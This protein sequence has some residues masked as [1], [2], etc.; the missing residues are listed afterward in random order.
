M[1]IK[2]ILG[3]LDPTIGTLAKS[4]KAKIDKMDGWCDNP[5]VEYCCKSLNSF[6]YLEKKHQAVNCPKCG[7]RANIK[8]SYKI[9]KK[10]CTAHVLEGTGVAC[11]TKVHAVSSFDCKLLGEESTFVIDTVGVMNSNPES[12]ASFASDNSS[13]M[14]NMEFPT[15]GLNVTVE[16]A[17]S[18]VIDIALHAAVYSPL[19][20]YVYAALPAFA[21]AGS[22]LPTFANAVSKSESDPSV[23]NL[24]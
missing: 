11:K 17:A 7:K 6:F 24:I 9:C 15:D 1:S 13:D 19:T 3:T 22:N 5:L 14:T 23:S 4:Q 12:D 21:P 2:F 8:C 18:G 10:C 20:D 16:P